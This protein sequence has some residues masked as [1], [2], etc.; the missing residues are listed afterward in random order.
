MSDQPEPTQFDRLEALTDPTRLALLESL[1]LAGEPMTTAALS[2]AVPDTGTGL[3]YQLRVLEKA[4][5]IKHESGKGRATRWSPLDVPV[6][7]T[8]SL[9]DADPATQLAIRTLERVM[10]ERVDVRW[11]SW[12]SAKRGGQWSPEW[13]DAEIGKQHRLRLTPDLLRELEDELGEVI[14]RFRARSDVVEGDDA[15]HVFINVMAHPI[16]SIK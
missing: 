15:E 3:T 4:G 7:W 5:L 11:R 2:R 6:E 9:G 14:D 10:W 8:S 16:R 13:V 1:R 12:L